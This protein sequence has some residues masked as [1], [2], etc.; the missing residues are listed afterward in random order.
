MPGLGTY[1][2]EWKVAF[3]GDVATKPVNLVP[4]AAPNEVGGFKVTEPIAAG[5]RAQVEAA[6]A[7]G[8]YVA[9]APLRHPLHAN[10][11]LAWTGGA[12]ILWTRKQAFAGAPNQAPRYT[13][14]L[15]I[16][17]AAGGA[18]TPIETREDAP[19]ASPEYAVYLVPGERFA[20]V[21]DVAGYG[22]EGV[23]GETAHAFRCD[24]SAK[25]CE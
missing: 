22:D 13:D 12:E 17:W 2:A 19:V 14:T 16:R 3:L 21:S 9:L 1:A 15:A 11:P 5:P 7:A 24:R 23:A 18:L 25:R 6:L 10:L 20:V 4:P 8:G